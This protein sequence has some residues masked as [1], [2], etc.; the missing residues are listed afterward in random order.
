MSVFQRILAG[1]VVGF[2]LLLT[3]CGGPG[4]T[5]YSGIYTSVEGT[6][7][8]TVLT[9]LDIDVAANGD[10]K[11]SITLFHY[12]QMAGL[13]TGKMIVTPDSLVVHGTIKG[14][15]FDMTIMAQGQRAASGTISPRDIKLVRPVPGVLRLT[16]EAGYKAQMKRAFGE[17]AP[18]T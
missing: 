6:G 16:T 9:R 1:L 3:A 15:K 14:N 11:G 12:N 7:R 17:H 4:Y 18:V 5:A 8:S 10:F 13:M 2:V